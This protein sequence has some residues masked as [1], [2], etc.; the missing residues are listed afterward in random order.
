MPSTSGIPGEQQAAI[1]RA[2]GV[3]ARQVDGNSN[4]QDRF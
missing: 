3:S 2:V 1:K 4:S